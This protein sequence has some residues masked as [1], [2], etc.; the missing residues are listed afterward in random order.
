MTKKLEPEERVRKEYAP[1][2]QRGQKHISFRIDLDL[3]EL[4]ERQPNKGRAINEALRQ[5]LQS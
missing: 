3:L 4:L 1:K 5:Y 2:G